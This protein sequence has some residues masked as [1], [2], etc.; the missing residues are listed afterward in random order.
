MMFEHAIETN[1]SNFCVFLRHIRVVYRFNLSIPFFHFIF[2][3]SYTYM[4]ISHILFLRSITVTTVSDAIVTTALLLCTW[5]Y[6]PSLP[7]LFHGVLFSPFS[8]WKARR[9]VW[10]A[11]SLKRHSA[12]ET[13][14]RHS[15]FRD[16]KN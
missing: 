13:K 6:F 2:L 1:I 9:S 11:Y 14:Q 3:S 15:L 10:K 16:V 4:W 5:S 12:K 7:F 8:I